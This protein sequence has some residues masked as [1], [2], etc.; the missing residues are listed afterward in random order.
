MCLAVWC[1]GVVLPVNFTGGNLNDILDKNHDGI[2]D[3]VPLITLGP[4][5]TVEDLASNVANNT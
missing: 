5:G 4:Q 3:A 1:I 2:L